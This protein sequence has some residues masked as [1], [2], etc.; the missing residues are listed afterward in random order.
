[1]FSLVLWIKS[2]SLW[3]KRHLWVLYSPSMSGYLSETDLLLLSL[4]YAIR[5]P[6]LCSSRMIMAGSTTIHHHQTLPAQRKEVPS[7][8]ESTQMQAGYRHC[9]F[10]GPPCAFEKRYDAL[11]R[12]DSWRARKSKFLTSLYFKA[13]FP[14]HPTPYR[15]AILTSAFWTTFS[16]DRQ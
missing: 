15:V 12:A 13:Q 11:W 9:Q 1:M 5:P 2:T 14:P 3:F 6:L 7:A 8:S 4:L 16:W 10:L